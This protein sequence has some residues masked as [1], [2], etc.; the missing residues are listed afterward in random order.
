[1]RVSV[2][3]MPRASREEVVKNAD[4]TLK[5]YLR[6][7]PVNGKANKSLVEILADYYRVKRSAVNIITGQRNNKKILEIT[8]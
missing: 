3:V 4:G 2:K 8:L 7:A 5:V 1:M 6:A